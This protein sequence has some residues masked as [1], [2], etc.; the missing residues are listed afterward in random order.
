MYNGYP[1]FVK[2]RKISEKY[3]D[4]PVK[5]WRNM[6]KE[7]IDTLKEYDSE[8]MPIIKKKKVE[9]EASA[10]NEG[11]QIRLTIPPETEM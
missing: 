3:A 2:A 5:T 11:H 7:V 4:Y 1:S 10:L 9:Y 6:F 8:E